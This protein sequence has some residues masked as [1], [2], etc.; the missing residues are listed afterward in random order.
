MAAC[1]LA[2]H[3]PYTP[4]VAKECDL[5]FNKMRQHIKNRK[6]SWTLAFSYQRK[7]AIPTRSLFM[8][9]KVKNRARDIPRRSCVCCVATW[10][11]KPADSNL[12][13]ISSV[14]LYNKRGKYDMGCQPLPDKTW[15]RNINR[16]LTSC[17]GYMLQ[18]TVVSW[19]LLLSFFHWPCDP[20][21]L[22]WSSPKHPLC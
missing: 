15:S 10:Y 8:H 7:N 19:A 3:A 1:F 4:G 6:R 20:P 11:P 14:C 9:N 18:W 13:I 17:R 16:A 22:P 2:A 12:W 21:W 5:M